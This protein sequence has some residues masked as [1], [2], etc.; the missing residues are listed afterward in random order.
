MC[1]NYKQATLNK[2]SSCQKNVCSYKIKVYKIIQFSKHYHKQFT[3]RSIKACFRTVLE[4]DTWDM[5]TVFA[6]FPLETLA[7]DFYLQSFKTFQLLKTI[8]NLTEALKK[9]LVY[10]TYNGFNLVFYLKKLYVIHF[11]KFC[12]LYRE[13]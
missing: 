13:L 7:W 1:S 11:S 12:K 10:N 4:L 8:P 5:F 3:G 6:L 2:A 9:T